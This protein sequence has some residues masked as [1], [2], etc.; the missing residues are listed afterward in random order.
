MNSIYSPNDLSRVKL[1]RVV[2]FLKYL[3]R[4]VSLIFLAKT[5]IWNK[6][7]FPASSSLNFAELVKNE[8]MKSISK[9]IYQYSFLNP[10]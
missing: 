1:G 9:N 3:A 7:T 5:L 2:T 8:L 4:V 10:I 6:V